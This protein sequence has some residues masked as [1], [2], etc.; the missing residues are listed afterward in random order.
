MYRHNQFE[1]TAA[2]RVFQDYIATQLTGVSRCQLLIAFV[3]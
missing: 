1:E 2:D 3:G